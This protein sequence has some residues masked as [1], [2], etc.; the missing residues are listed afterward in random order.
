MTDPVAVEAC[1]VGHLP[2]VRWAVRELRIDAVLDE[3]SPKHDL[4]HVSDADCVVAMILNILSGRLALY[5]MQ[6]WLSFTDVELLIGE[7]READFFH[8]T[9]LGISLDH[10]DELGTDVVMGRIVEVYLARDDR[11]TEYSAHLDTTSVSL[12]GQ[13]HGQDG[14]E[15][16]H[17]FS[18][19]KRP[20]LKQLIFGLVLHG[21][22]GIPLVSD[23]AAGNTA[24][25]VANRDLL[26]RLGP[27]LP[28]EDEVTVV[29]DCKAV[30]AVTIGRVID[31]GLHIVSL[32]PDTF[33]M[34]GTLIEAAWEACPDLEEWPELAR[35]PGRRKAD[36]DKVYRGWSTVESFGIERQVVGPDG[37]PR[38][39]RV[40]Q[41][42]RY[43]VVFSSRLAK[44][45]DATLGAK[46]AREQAKLDTFS[47]AANRKGYACEADALAAANRT[48]ARLK[49]LGARPVVEREERKL[50]RPRRGRP[51]KGEEAPTEVVYTVRF[52]VERD[53]EAIE[54]HRQRASCFVLI[55]A[56]TDD[57]TWPDARIL[58]EYRKQFLIENHTGFRWLKSEAAVSPMFLKTTRRIRAM[59]L[60]LTLALMVRNFIQFSLHGALAK[61]DGGI[62]HPYTKKVERRLTTEMAMAWFM[63]IQSMRLSIAGSP[64]TR[65][66]PRFRDTARQILDLL[67]VDDSWFTTPPQPNTS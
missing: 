66:T 58:G 26:A 64:W 59:G 65:Q 12:Y 39:T 49:M 31:Q 14:P 20:D 29:A 50:K 9:R 7:G 18:K 40:D 16:T 17:G 10:L 24:D 6:E 43:L 57:S 53:E 22:A 36:P 61:S 62:R 35:S 8:D 30:D 54:R 34:R 52:E 55:S 46:L 51:K 11:P 63:G 19:D 13:Y 3:L 41:D 5:A 42:M 56:H 4:A 47:K 37:A 38:P 45:F 48:T 60:V 1:P 32:V 33:K 67:G 28:P 25:P 21:S 2:L 15:V 44:R 23:V 27:L